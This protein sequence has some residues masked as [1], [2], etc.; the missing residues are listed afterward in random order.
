MISGVSPGSCVSEQASP[1]DI[2]TVTCESLA[3]FQFSKGEKHLQDARLIAMSVIS[4]MNVIRADQDFF[5]H[6]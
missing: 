5:L 2:R 3:D 6:V 1:H 4:A